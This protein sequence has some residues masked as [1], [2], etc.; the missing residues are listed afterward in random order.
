MK[1]VLFKLLLLT[2]SGLILANEPDQEELSF[3]D[4]D[5]EIAEESLFGDPNEGDP[6]GND[7]SEEEQSI[8][9]N[10]KTVRSNKLDTSGHKKGPLKPDNQ[11]R[12]DAFG[13]ELDPESEF[14]EEYDPFSDEEDPFADDWDEE[15]LYGV[16][17]EV[18]RSEVV[19]E[20]T[21]D[22]IFFLN[23]QEQLVNEYLF[24][25]D[26][27]QNQEAS[28]SLNITL[29]S[30]IRWKESISLRI[31]MPQY[32]KILKEFILSTGLVKN[33]LPCE[34]LKWHI[35]RI[36]YLTKLENSFKKKLLQISDKTVDSIHT[37]NELTK[38]P[39]SPFDFL[40]IPFG[41]TK[42]IFKKIYH[43]TLS[44]P[45]MGRDD[46]LY[47]EHYL[48]KGT[49]FIVIFY[50]TKESRYYKYEILGYPFS[51]NL[52]NEKVRSQAKLLEKI[53]EQNIGPADRINRLSYFD[54]KSGTVSPYIV[55]HRETHSA[56][57]S[58]GL[59]NNLYY[60]KLTVN[61]RSLKP[62]GQQS[63]K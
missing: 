11:K 2:T 46:F 14:H 7:T 1:I 3:G 12:L 30:L 49:P 25:N 29:D 5:E 40:S 13:N 31:Q 56:V 34:V 45:L 57:I 32:K 21:K 8:E 61:N 36:T 44:Y 37:F 19:I 33:V 27:D 23:L 53:M 41:L 58:I 43:R 42:K 9:P 50:F 48:L 26:L 38:N 35:D 6:F 10:S 15:T 62:L 24:C 20:K 52:L 16:P 39:V 28:D 54:I 22:D 17:E 59:D 51:G 55:W 63:K 60:A 4:L 18:R 47:I